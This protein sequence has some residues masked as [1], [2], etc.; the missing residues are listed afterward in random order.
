MKEV[1]E[2]NVYM[3]KAEIK[4]RENDVK[5]AKKLLEAVIRS[6]DVHP[7]DWAISIDYYTTAEE[8]R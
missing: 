4:L 6:F 2:V 5:K 3:L 1:K 8:Y 7:K